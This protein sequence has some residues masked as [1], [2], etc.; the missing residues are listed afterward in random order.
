[1]SGA[2]APRIRDAVLAMVTARELEIAQGRAKLGIST[3]ELNDVIR[4]PGSHLMAHMRSYEKQGYVVRRRAIE[5]KT[6]N[7]KTTSVTWRIGLNS[8]AS[9]KAQRDAKRLRRQEERDARF[10]RMD[11]EMAPRP[12]VVI[13]PAPSRD[14]MVREI[15][16]QLHPLDRAWGRAA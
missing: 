15:V 4:L 11:E 7:F 16:S 10:T 14:P 13:I 5:I 6:L 2:P 3:S 12:R 9:T 8:P 1:M